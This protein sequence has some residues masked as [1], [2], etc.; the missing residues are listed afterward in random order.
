[1]TSHLP[2]GRV[3]AAPTARVCDWTL[4]SWNHAKKEVAVK[5]VKKLGVSNAA[6]GTEDGEIY[7]DG[8]RDSSEGTEEGEGGQTPA[9]DAMW[10][11]AGALAPARWDYHLSASRTPPRHVNSPPGWRASTIQMRKGHRTDPLSC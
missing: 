7:E 11:E 6:D 1:M 3:E 5:W 4:R 10:A 9:C 2:T 8:E